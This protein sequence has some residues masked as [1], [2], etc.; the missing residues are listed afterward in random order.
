MLHRGGTCLVVALLIAAGCEKKNPPPTPSP[1]GNGVESIRG[2]E[3]LGWDQRAFDTA[4]LATFRYAIYVDGNRSE[5]A[6]VNCGNTAGVN[7]FDCSS[8]LPTMPPGQ[9]TIELASFIVDGGATL[10]SG[11]SSP[12]RVNVTGTA[13]TAL[14]PGDA[15]RTSDGVRL[16]VELVADGF[17][18]ITDLAMD[19]DGR[20][21]VA[22]RNGQVRIVA[23]DARRIQTTAAS[24]AGSLLSIAVAP[25]FRDTQ[26]MYAV[27]L[28]PH[29]EGVAFRVVRYR[30]VQG[31]LGQRA[32]LLGDITSQAQEP[33][34][35]VRFGPDGHLYVGL[36]DGGDA[37]NAADP[38]SLNG[39]ILRLNPDGTT[40]DDQ[41]GPVHRAGYRSPRGLAW[42]RR[43]TLWVVDGEP[44]EGERLTASATSYALRTAP[45]DVLTYAGDAIP[46]FQGDLF[47]AAADH[48]LR[49]RSDPRSPARVIATE[50]LLAGI[51]P[52]RALAIGPDGMLYFATAGTVAK[53][54]AP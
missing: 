52:I 27:H 9:H 19:P 33:S 35:A 44:R 41:R 45:S 10:E 3:R 51:G 32:V 7:G 23:L 20:L 24:E 13:A 5:A 8:R 15:G 39:K 31:M 38:A 22:E 11:R 2:T 48:I 47:V 21:F 50:R 49:V 4:E 14:R 40:P 37:R 46:A 12:L 16:R 17:N 26:L 53:L 42:S 18:D 54:V 6:D 34:A 29:A 30:E 25:D 1:N 36:D 28:V 43:A